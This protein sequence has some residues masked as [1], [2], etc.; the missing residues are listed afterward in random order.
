M[1]GFVLNYLI[2][3]PEFEEFGLWLGC[4]IITPGYL[5]IILNYKTKYRRFEMEIWIFFFFYIYI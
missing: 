1:V 2:I 5:Y 4:I 3:L